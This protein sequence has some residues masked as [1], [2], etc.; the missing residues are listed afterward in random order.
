M[1]TIAKYMGKLEKE[2]L[3]MLA[4]KKSMK[5]RL[6]VHMDMFKDEIDENGE[7]KTKKESIVVIT[8]KYHTVTKDNIKEVLRLEA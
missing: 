1:Q 3:K 5:I 4:V 7:K 2:T 6:R 8:K